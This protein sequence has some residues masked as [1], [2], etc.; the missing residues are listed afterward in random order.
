MGSMVSLNRGLFSRLRRRRWALSLAVGY[1][2]LLNALLTTLAGNA[3]LAAALDPLRAP[4]AFCGEAGKAA[5]SSVPANPQQHPAECPLCGPACPMGGCV[6]V[7]RS[8]VITV[9]TPPSSNGRRAELSAASNSQRSGSLYRSD[10]AS[11]APPA[12]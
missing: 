12:A 5:G 7:G 6:P 9:P 8:A 2:L 11:Q 1:A 3:A 4:S 10:V